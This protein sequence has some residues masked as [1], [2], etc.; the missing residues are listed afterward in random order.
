[1]EVLNL[2]PSR[3]VVRK[4]NDL[5]IQ[6][7]KKYLIQNADGYVTLNRDNNEN[8]WTLNDGMIRRHLQG[9]YTYGIFSGGYFNKFITFDVDYTE[10]AMA[11]WVTL[12]L[13]DTLVRE[14]DIRYQDIHVSLSG[15]KGYHL[16]L[17]FDKPIYVS[18]TEAFYKKVLSK[19]G[20][21]PAGGEVE[22]RPTW[23]QGVKL[24]LGIHQRTGNRCWYVNNQTLEPF[25]SF[26]YILDIE[27]M[28]AEVIT[29]I[30]FGL[31]MEQAEEFER[32]VR[33]TDI[34]ANVQST[35]DALQS[36][37]HLIETNRLL[38]S[39][40]RHKATY[41]VA[42]FGNMHGWKREDTVE[43]ILD[44]LHNTP[45]EFFSEGSTPDYWESEAIRLV[46]YAYDNNKTLGN[47]DKP[48]T[49]YKSE[50]IEVLKVGTFRQK[51]LAYAM[52]VT[53]KRYGRVF[54]LARSSAKQMLNTKSNSLITRGVDVLADVGFIEIV[55]RNKVDRALSR[56]V[57]QRRHMPNKYRLMTAEPE[58]D[59]PSIIVTKDDDMIEVTFALCSE[60]EIRRH[61]KDYEYNNR[62]RR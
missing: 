62:W 29:E 7:R 23:T 46:D 4:I 47:A 53:S 37:N 19:A 38:A 27:P 57:G 21:L 32:V 43:L 55:R 10:E 33:S 1:M 61:I 40:T 14:F 41:Q 24:P 30:D 26:D 6:T 34:E 45:R 8:I 2:K 42:C 15:S 5:Y 12:K 56:A 22:F 3:R 16:D 51:Q 50:I 13:V 58:L 25:K 35:S 52:L 9:R 49:I 54:Y 18:D 39:N 44:I 17:F 60:E 28:D 59:E 48:V 31:T 36:A 11:R 20:D